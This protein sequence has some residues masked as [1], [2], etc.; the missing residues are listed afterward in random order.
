MIITLPEKLLLNFRVDAMEPLFSALGLLPVSR[1]FGLKP[2]NPSFGG[3]KLVRCLCAVSIA[4]LPFCSA[5]SA[6]LLRSWRIV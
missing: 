4:C 5:P 1:D 2:G 6:A 3:A